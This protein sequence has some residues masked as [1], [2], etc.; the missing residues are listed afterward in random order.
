MVLCLVKW[1]CRYSMRK[2]KIQMKKKVIFLLLVICLGVS[3]FA[4]RRVQTKEQTVFYADNQEKNSVEDDRYTIERIEGDGIKNS[5]GQAVVYGYYDKVV[6]GDSKYL[7]CNHVIDKKA[8]EFQSQY[9]NL[10]EQVKEADGVKSDYREG[11]FPYYDTCEVREHPKV[12]V[13]LQTDVR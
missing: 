12:C 13:N 11:E 1:V 3:V 8:A 10:K 9:E 5:L 6:F 7:A 4:Y 2:E